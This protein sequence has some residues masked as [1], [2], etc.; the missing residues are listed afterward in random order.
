VAKNVTGAGRGS[1]ED[2][3][4]A[5]APEEEKSRAAAPDD[6]MVPGQ[7]LIT[8]VV[9]A[10]D[11]A[12]EESADPPRELDLPRAP[13]D[14][15]AVDLVRP[16]HTILGR[17]IPGGQDR[18]V[19]YGLALLLRDRARSDEPKPRPPQPAPTIGERPSGTIDRRGAAHRGRSAGPAV[20]SASVRRLPLR[21]PALG[22]PLALLVGLVAAFISWV[23]AGPFWLANGAGTTGTATVT[24]CAQR[25]LADLCQGRFAADNGSFVVPARLASLDP[26]D[27]RPGS[28]VRA[29]ILHPDSEVAYA[30]PVAG[31]HLRW[32][33]GF[34]AVLGCGFAVG[35]ATGVPRLRREGPQRIA[36]LWALS[37]AGPLLLLLTMLTLALI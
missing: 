6:S 2:S 5:S 27:R 16:E 11:S 17:P 22:L 33:L 24:S 19:D 9:E 35:T 23:S 36:L 12:P 14:E 30:G 25:T 10:L 3:G 26:A 28:R 37:F 7:L 31:L 13:R 34:G 18:W 21:D 20:L 8:D 4:A 32:V 29:R 1:D 15:T